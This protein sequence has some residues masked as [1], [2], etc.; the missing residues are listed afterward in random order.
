MELLIHW[1][2][3]VVAVDSFFLSHFNSVHSRKFACVRSKQIA[4]N[5]MYA[6][7]SGSFVFC[8]RFYDLQPNSWKFEMRMKLDL[9]IAAAVRIGIRCV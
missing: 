3:G 6:I 4:N 1:S 7:C 8:S 9:S 2:S 5:V